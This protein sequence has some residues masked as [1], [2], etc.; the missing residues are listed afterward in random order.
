MSHWI[1]DLITH[2]PDLPLLPWADYKV[3]FGLWNHV[4]LTL[5]I[6]L[7]VFFTGVFFYSKT[8]RA[9]NKKGSIGLWVLILFLLLVYTLNIFGPPPPSEEPIAIVGLSLWLVVAWGY[10]I[11]RNRSAVNF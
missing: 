7:T 4:G 10:W 6:E 1:L 3:G 5:L 8:T 9:E 2:R 11:D